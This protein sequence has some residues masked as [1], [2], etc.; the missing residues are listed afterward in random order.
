MPG[1]QSERFRPIPNTGPGS[2]LRGRLLFHARR[3]LD[4][5]VGTVFASC[6]PWLRSR[7][8]TVLDVGCGDQPYRLALSAGAS[9]IGLDLAIAGDA[10]DK[11]VLPDI[12]FYAG[13]RFPFHDQ[14]FDAV[15]HTE[16]LE[17]IKEYSSFLRE[18]ARVLRIDGEMCFTVP[19]QAR[20][21]YIPYDYWRFTPTSINM[22]PSRAGFADV[23]VAACGS[24]VVV[25][26]AKVLG[27]CYR[28]GIAT[29]WALVPLSPVIVTAL[30][31]AHAALRFGWGSTDDCLGYTVTARRQGQGVS[32]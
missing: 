14:S 8:G 3:L 21:H 11:N 13:D 20:F 7:H 15:F 26:C 2:G 12:A 22:L 28:L 6:Q 18:C 27:L 32:A 17:H 16:T 4:L 9:Y 23:R 19:F 5:Q 25:A 30:L 31:L 24:D 1:S 29:P 10:F